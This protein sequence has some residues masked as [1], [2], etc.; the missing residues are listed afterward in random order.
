MAAAFSRYILRIIRWDVHINE[1]ANIGRRK[2]KCLSIFNEHFYQT[3]LFNTNAPFDV[4]DG[5]E[6]YVHSLN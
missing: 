6:I 5:C 3:Y 1:T 2:L 4:F